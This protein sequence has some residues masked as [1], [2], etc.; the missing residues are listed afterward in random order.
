[1]Q[2]HHLFAEFTV[3]SK[4]Q[5]LNVIRAP[6][7]TVILSGLAWKYWQKTQLSEDGSQLAPTIYAEHSN[8]HVMLKRYYVMSVFAG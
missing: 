4:V 3:N 8:C 2:L 7:V 1:M 5:P 6:A